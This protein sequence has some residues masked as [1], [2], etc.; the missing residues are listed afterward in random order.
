MKAWLRRHIDD[1]LSVN[2]RKEDAEFVAAMFVKFQ[3][4]FPLWKPPAHVTIDDRALTFTGTWPTLAE[5]V[6]FRPWNRRQA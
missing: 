1:H 4:S 6:E 2:S 5:I 3:L